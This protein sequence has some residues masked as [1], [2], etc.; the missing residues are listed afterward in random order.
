YHDV[1]HV[2]AGYNTTPEGETLV[3]AFIAG[4]RQ[5]RADHGFFTALFVVSIF[6]TGIDVTPIDVGARTGTIGKVAEQFLEA[7]DRGSAVPSD[8]SRDMDC[9]PMLEL[10]LEEARQRLKIRPKDGGHPWDYD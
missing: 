9:W 1:T 6:S 3:G 4:Y 10:P 5:N 8:L 7:I 2:L